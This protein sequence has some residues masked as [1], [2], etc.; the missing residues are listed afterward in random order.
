MPK[1]PNYPQMTFLFYKVLTHNVLGFK[2]WP[3][4]ARRFSM[5]Y[6]NFASES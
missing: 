5:I 4:N 6:S 2:V 1:I 3:L